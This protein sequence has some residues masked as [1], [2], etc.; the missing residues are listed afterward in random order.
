MYKYLYK[1]SIMSGISLTSSMR[2]NLLS[3]KNTSSLIDMTQNRLSTGKKVNSA[4][5][6]PSSYY[7]ARSLNNRANDLSSLLDS[8]GQAISTI[9]AASETLESG[10]VFLEQATAIAEQA[11]TE[12]VSKTLTKSEEELRAEGYELI[13]SDMDAAA[14]EAK[15]VAGAKV[16]LVGDISLDR[17]LNI[18]T[19]GVEVNGNGYTINYTASS[20][21][22]SVINV[23]GAGATA[24]IKNIAI[25]ASGEQL[26]GISATN[27]GKITLDNANNIKVSGAGAQ[28]IWFRDENLYNGKANTAALLS[29]IGVD[30]LA[31]TAC[32]QFYVGDKNGTFGQ[33]NWYL[34]A[35]GELMNVYGYD[36][37][38][39][40]GAWDT[41]GAVGDNKTA[42]NNT[43]STLA[44]KGAEAATLTE[45]WY[46]SSSETNSY[47]SWLLDLSVG[48]RDRSNEYNSGYVR[49]FQLL[50]NCFNP[51][52]LS[53][54]AGGGSGSSAA[55]KVGQVMYAD[56][57][58]GD[59]ADYKND[60]SMTAVGVITEVLDDGSVKIMSLKDLTFSSNNT[61]GNFDPENPYG[62][63][64]KSTY[65]TTDA[66]Y[67]Q[68]VTG[69]QNYSG[70]QTLTAYQSSGDV[71]LSFSA[72]TTSID[73]SF[74]EQYNEVVSQYDSLINDGSYKGVNLLKN[75]SLS[76]RFN[77]DGSS[78][79]NI[80]GKDMS[81]AILGMT[82]AKWTNVNDVE[83]SVS[84]LKN[85]IN[86]VRT[87]ST[88]L[89]NNYSIVQTRENFTENLINVL[90]E[91]ADK[92]TLADMNEESANILALQTRQQLAINS[93]SLAAQSAQAV[94]KLF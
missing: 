78:A 79:L 30:A 82:E 19:S 39:I 33:G 51:L 60:G 16:A 67:S 29:E 87:F 68:D 84:Q 46:W 91:G 8:M 38:Q 10:L 52:T 81:S 9:K 66:K 80:I 57:T 27:G 11:R 94:L 1:V 45:G 75:E 72:E 14:I 86:L 65:H 32:N 89:G 93:L 61:V 24:N 47:I 43:L 70:A 12:T 58:W 44:S 90:T 54:D 35:I 85:A 25:N 42:I 71:K 20:A 49:S 56:K 77:E 63:S 88:E 55:P 74:T 50:E 64:V 3:L 83:A 21:G 53:A 34:P 26:Y 15:L 2:S 6:N 62:G 5:D 28:K 37:S 69:I 4:I 73:N 17:G 59:A 40:T 76:V 41:T 92:L 22:E 13:T 23:N 31:A 36:A 7:T 48:A 18:S